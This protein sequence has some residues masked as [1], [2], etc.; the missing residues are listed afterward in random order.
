[1]SSKNKSNSDNTE[2]D[3]KNE[4]ESQKD[5]SK[6]E[7]NSEKDKE[8][9][10]EK[11]KKKKAKSDD[12][13]SDNEGS[14]NDNK[15]KSDDEGSGSDS[16]SSKKKKKKGSKKGKKKGSKKGKDKSKKK[17]GEKKKKR[18]F[19]DKNLRDIANRVG[20]YAVERVYRNDIVT[21]EAKQHI[22]ENY[23]LTRA[24]FESHLEANR[25]KRAE[26]KAQKEKE[27]DKDKKEKD[28]DK[29]SKD[30]DKKDKDKDA[31]KDDAQDKKKK[32]G[33]SK[34]DAKD[35]A[36]KEKTRREPFYPKASVLVYARELFY[37]MVREAKTVDDKGKRGI[38]PENVYEY[39][40]E[41]GKAN[42]T[43]LLTIC[44]FYAAWNAKNGIFG[45]SMKERPKELAECADELTELAEYYVRDDGRFDCRDLPGAFSRCYAEFI[46]E[47]F[48]YMALS[49]AIV[50]RASTYDGAKAF[51][52]FVPM[53]LA[54]NGDI[55]HFAPILKLVHKLNEV[56]YDKRVKALKDKKKREEDAKNG[57]TAQDRSRMRKEEKAKKKKA[58]KEEDGD[59]SGSDNDDDDDGSKK[60][61]KKGS[62]KGSKKGKSKS[63]KKGKDKEKS[64]KKSKSKSDDDGSDNDAGDF[65]N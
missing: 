46:I 48:S 14:D 52:Q 61:K 28:G 31:S 64:K 55:S 20:Y 13:G 27:G 38:T 26:E 2:N 58:K 21:H 17:S 33:R 16:D 63:S 36:E 50:D 29:G 5:S 19:D 51:A 12:E 40:V 49:G 42:G 41:T 35:G 44:R 60:K 24:E 34:K 4:V 54:Y 1:M 32:A 56:Q 57:I 45:L 10:K 39:L 30:S 43:I 23:F 11:S 22:K 9:E 18:K 8:K 37:E 25:K 65:E 7:K 53:M 6:K 47:L 59:K 62:K 15:A 3:K